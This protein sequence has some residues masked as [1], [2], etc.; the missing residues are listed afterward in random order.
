MLKSFITTIKNSK[1]STNIDEKDKNFDNQKSIN[2]S[3]S[4]LIKTE[5]FIIDET[6]SSSLISNSN[7]SNLEITLNK[8][9]KLDELENDFDLITDQFESSIY[10]SL[11]KSE[12]CMLPCFNVSC[13]GKIK[14]F[15]LFAVLDIGGS[16]LRISVVEF[17]KNNQ[18]TCIVNKSWL[19]DDSNKHLDESF[20]KWIVNNFISIINKEL[21][22][23][24]KNNLNGKIN[25]GITWSF[26]I[27]QNKAPNRGIIS[28]LGKGFSI[29]EKFKGKDLKD[30]FECYFESSNI[31][32]EVCAIVNDSISVFIAG[33]FF[34]NAKLGLV[35][36]TG[37]NSCFLI[38][39]NMLGE[40][41]RECFQNNEN[42]S[43]YLVNTEASFLGH[44][45]S[46]YITPVDHEL[47]NTWKLLKDD[48]YLPP[49]LTTI[50][51]VFQPLELLTSGRYLP[52]IIRLII[53]GRFINVNFSNNFLSNE[54]K[55]EYGLSATRLS[56]LYQNNNKSTEIND[57]SMHLNL[58]V[59]TIISRASMVLASYII[60]LLRVTKFTDV[61]NL[62]I[63]VV[64]SVLQHFPGYKE[65][66]LEILIVK[67]KTQNIPNLKFKFIED[68]SIY[69][70]A[71]ASFV[72]QIHQS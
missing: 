6:D 71:I 36:G 21:L 31:P 39:S 35:Q 59:D 53:V 38:D 45:L 51:G 41:K 46:D 43:N 19:I 1:R 11:L 26:P 10:E 20:F 13:D 8:Y 9:F 58:I 40:T 60:A 49:H 30:I 48:H 70:A 22:L 44:H 15:G 25:V 7:V 37:I 52:E 61:E 47:N 18:A 16:T 23:K 55:F 24:L 57:D 14:P 68:S 42:I 67:S 56:D 69:G 5:T 2:I 65:K 12:N 50:Y 34:N 64:G 33:L 3:E 63:S 72:N 66:V 62:D 32:I 17:L 29:S 28:D 54:E 4:S 27:I